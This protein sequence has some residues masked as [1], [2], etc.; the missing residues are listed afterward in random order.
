M[1]IV[2]QRILIVKTSSLGEVM[3]SLQVAQVLKENDPGIEISC[4]ARRRFET[5]VKASSA[6]DH[7]STF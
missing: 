2:T 7:T 4:V 1:A 6:V 3:H 5:L